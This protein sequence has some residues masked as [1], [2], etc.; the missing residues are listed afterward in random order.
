MSSIALVRSNT[1]PY[2][3]RGFKFGSLAVHAMTAKLKSANISLL[4]VYAL[5]TYDNTL[6]Y[7][8]IYIFISAALDQTAIF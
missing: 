3:W 2:S 8:L 6:P 7:R 4:H 5:Y 1:V